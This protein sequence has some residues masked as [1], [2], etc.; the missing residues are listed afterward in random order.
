MK[1]LNDTEKYSDEH[2]EEFFDYLGEITGA[3]TTTIEQTWNL[4]KR[5]V[6]NFNDSD[7]ALLNDLLQWMQEKDLIENKDITA[8]DLL[9]LEYIKNAGL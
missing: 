2:L 6:R 7:I 9:E 3:D 5:E 8:D 1:G 4:S